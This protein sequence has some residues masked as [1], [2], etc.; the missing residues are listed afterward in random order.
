MVCIAKALRPQE[1][2]SLLNTKLSL[3]GVCLFL[4]AVLEVWFK[5]SE[6]SGLSQTQRNFLLC[7]PW[8]GWFYLCCNFC[9]Q[10]AVMQWINQVGTAKLGEPCPDPGPQLLVVKCC[11][12][13]FLVLRQN[14]GKPE[15]RMWR[16][17]YQ[18]TLF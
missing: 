16:N 1:N 7:A 18:K 2:P 5:I 9:T 11:T 4:I 6:L 10:T 8:Q 12:G 15:I 14:S 3:F 17:P 13:R